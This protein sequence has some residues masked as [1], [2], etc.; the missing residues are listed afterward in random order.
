[1]GIGRRLPKNLQNEQPACEEPS[2]YAKQ[3]VEEHT[4][5]SEKVYTLDASTV[6]PLLGGFSGMGRRGRPED[7]AFTKSKLSGIDNSCP[8]RRK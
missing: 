7:I 8:N 6:F 3:E 5:M 4:P 1:M 2:H